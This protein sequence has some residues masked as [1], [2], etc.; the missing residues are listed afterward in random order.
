MW[1]RL[2]EVELSIGVGADVLGGASGGV[3]FSACCSG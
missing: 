3:E 2:R 1:L